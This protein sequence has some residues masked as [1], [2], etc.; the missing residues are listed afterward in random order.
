[1]ACEFAR[2]RASATKWVLVGH[3]IA[4]ALLCCS[5]ASAQQ[6]PDAGT[7][8]REQ[9]TPPMVAPKP[10]VPIAP[11]L[12]APTPEEGPRVLVKGIRF[13]GNVLI[14][15]AELES[16]LKSLIG[17]QVSLGQLRRA[18]SAI[19]GYYAQKG[20][21]ARVV[22]PPQEIKDGVVTYQIIEG[23]RGNLSLQQK[24]KRIP[25]EWVKSLVANRL[26]ASSH[27][28]L[29]NMGEAAAILNEQPGLEVELELQ[30]GLREGDVD[31]SIKAKEKPLLG[32]TLGA[33]NQAS[34]ST[35]EYQ[36]QGSLAFNNLT[37]LLDAASLLATTTEGNTYV[38]G[39][40]SLPVGSSGLRLGIN[41]ST[42][43]YR[44]T[45]SS[46]SALKSTGTADTVGLNATYPLARRNDRVVTLTASTDSKDL[47]DR[48]VA[49]ETSNRAVQVTALG[50]N[51]WVAPAADEWLGGGTTSFGA[52]VGFGDSR[53]H[54]ATARAADALARRVEG[55]FAKLGYT[56]GHLRPLGADWSMNA[57]L[58]GQ[59]ADKNLDSTERFS[60]GGPSAVRAY[61]VGEATGDEGWLLNL[62]FQR[63]VADNVA[64][65]LFVDTGSITVNH[66][67]YAGWN[68]GN[69]RLS[70][71]YQ[72]S[73]VGVGLDWRIVGNALLNATLATPLGSNPGRDVN[74]H[75]ADGRKNRL[76]LWLSLNAQF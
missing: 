25:A 66:Q 4:G 67:T 50:I 37:G 34:R 48:T 20:Y 73:G 5:P 31:V 74:N 2:P 39:D 22:L 1:M 45:Q 12:T 15:S 53:Q 24:G 44:V 17:Q 75:D 59:V 63:P 33:N 62:N 26:G 18:A 40:Y 8:L 11:A 42:M 3:G 71:R 76:R 57:S 58:R 9:P 27:L 29:I 49:G 55:S 61:P 56:L 46:M 23:K 43:R 38:R 10:A 70:N 28:D 68:A 16:V 35:G 14:P 69:P 65:T 64:A 47:I 72:L 52:T 41:A 6:Q 60:L 21:L 19:I 13:T 30:P 54:N 51:G 32:A 7:L 36:A